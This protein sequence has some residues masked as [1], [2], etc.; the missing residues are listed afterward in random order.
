MRS[1]LNVTMYFNDEEYVPKTKKTEQVR[2]TVKITVKNIQA[3]KYSESVVNGDIVVFR[4][5]RYEIAIIHTGTMMQW[6]VFADDGIDG[7]QGI[8]IQ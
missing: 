5:A 6:R 1:H 7:E 8:H 4:R 3:F 2:Q